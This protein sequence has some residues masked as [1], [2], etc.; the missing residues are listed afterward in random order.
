MNKNLL[1]KIQ[2]DIGESAGSYCGCYDDFVNQMV[3]GIYDGTPYETD[4][5]SLPIGYCSKCQKKVNDEK[6]A[7]IHKTLEML[8]P[9]Y[10][11]CELMPVNVGP[12]FSDGAARMVR[13]AGEVPSGMVSRSEVVARLEIKPD[14]VERYIRSG[15]LRTDG[16]KKFITQESFDELKTLL[17]RQR[18]EPSERF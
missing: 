7:S 3:N 1:K 17:I 9:M 10:E 13:K 15:R 8:L 18:N 14:D 11:N 4:D 6:I 2:A 12:T 5:S 16:G